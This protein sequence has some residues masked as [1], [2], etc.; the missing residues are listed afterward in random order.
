V[1]ATLEITETA[2]KALVHRA[3]ATL[4]ERIEE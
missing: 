4:A 2:V 3:R 1:A